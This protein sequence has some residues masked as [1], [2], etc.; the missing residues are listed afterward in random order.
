MAAREQ[1][2]VGKMGTAEEVAARCKHTSGQIGID[3]HR[4]TGITI[5]AGVLGIEQHQLR[6]QESLVHQ[7]QS[8]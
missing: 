4:D 5:D 3:P 7:W 2:T 6:R 1:S 8:A